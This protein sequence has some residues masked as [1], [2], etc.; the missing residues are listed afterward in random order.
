MLSKIKS[1]ALHGLEGYLIEV[2]SDVS[3]GMPYW[4][5][6]GLPDV[7][8]KE[9]KE[10]VRA[11]IKNSGFEFPSR[12]IILNLSPADVKKEGTFFDL[13]IAIGL[14]AN[15]GYIPQIEENIAFVGELSLDGKVN[16]INGVLPICIEAKKL[17]IKK[18][19]VPSENAKEGAIVEQIEVIGVKSLMQTVTY[20]RKN[21]QIIPEKTNI[22]ELFLTNNQYDLDFAEVKGQESAKRALEI[23]AAGGHNCL[24]I[25]SPGVGKTMLAKR[26][27]SILPDLSFNEALEITKIYSIAGILPKNKKLVVNRPF[28]EPHHTVSIASLIGGGK[29]PKPGEVSLSHYGVL[30]LDE[31]TEFNK[32][33]LETLRG[34]VEDGKIVISRTNSTVTYPCEFMLIAAMN[35]CPCGYFGSKEKICTCSKAAIDRYM[36][37]ISGPLLDRIDIQIEVSQSKYQDINKNQ[38]ETSIKIKQRVNK[39]K[40]IQLK[41]YKKYEIFSNSQMTPALINKYCKLDEKSQKLLK[42]AFERLN[43]STRAYNRILKVARTIADLKQKNNIEYEDLAEAI[44][45]RSLD[46]KYWKN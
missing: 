14:L 20:L 19:I 28:R 43:L 22:K 1:I 33:T 8:V 12:K 23:A 34:P 46:R 24:L 15:F 40:K 13:P 39:A 38:E 21:I 10:R 5:T 18:I 9:A 2:Q 36:G 32:A 35:P 30:F 29:I 37:K 27:V 26:I 41:R 45:Y 44:Q 3:A 4:E 6:V 16:R 25:G 17:G 11:A 31:L 42:G 7:R